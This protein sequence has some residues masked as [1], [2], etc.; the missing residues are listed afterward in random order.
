MRRL[1]IVLVGT[2]LLG[3]L[4]MQSQAQLAIAEVIKAGV[5]RVIKAVDLRIQRLQNETI[6]LQNAQKLL[7]NTLSKFRLEE[8]ADWSDKQREQYRVYF[9][10][11]QRV[12]SLITY[13]QRIREITDK[14]VQIVRSYRQAWDLITKGDHYTAQEI[15]YMAVVYAGLIE[16]TADHVGDLM[17][18][19][20]SFKTQMSDAERLEMINGIAADVDVTYQDLIAFNRENAML[21]FRRTKDAA[22]VTALRKLYGLAK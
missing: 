12:K 15:E 11:L 10:E 4:P 22:D 13:Y 2:V 3:L 20:N 8:I 6:W 5:K 16:A 9:D 1:M 18:V 19:V 17:L 14:Q 7:E 21:G